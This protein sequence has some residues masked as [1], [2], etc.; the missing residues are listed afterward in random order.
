MRTTIAFSVA[1]LL[2][3]PQLTN[4]V[5]IER[6]HQPLAWAHVRRMTE[7]A[8]PD[9][10][11]LG[12]LSDTLSPFVHTN[13]LHDSKVSSTSASNVQLLGCVSNFCPSVFMYSRPLVS[14]SA[15]RLIGRDG[16]AAGSYSGAGGSAQG[17]SVTD[18][19]TSPLHGL[20]NIGS[21]ASVDSTSFFPSLMMFIDNAGNGS[22]ATSGNA[23]VG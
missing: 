12:T 7:G 3:S 9:L 13:H 11:D 22:T 23:G 17:G 18:S 10:G 4:C 20:M 15:R 1:G 5:P 8:N 2:L 21:S 14:I 6:A 19:N 16:L